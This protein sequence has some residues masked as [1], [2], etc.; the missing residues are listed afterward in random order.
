MSTPLTDEQRKLVEDNRWF[1]ISIAEKMTECKLDLDDRRQAGIIGLI[2]AVKKH[3]PSAGAL[4]TY[5]SR[6]IVNEIRRAEAKQKMIWIPEHM[7]MKFSDPKSKAAREKYSK[8]AEEAGEISSFSTR[9]F[10]MAWVNDDQSDKFIDNERTAEIKKAV[11]EA[12]KSLKAS[13]R[14]MIRLRVFKGM[15]YREIGDKHEIDRET[16]SRRVKLILKK[17]KRHPAINRVA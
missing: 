6:W 13:E 4:S 12:M 11:N 17:L 14:D 5:A 1:A 10:D 7:R 16:V 2:E 3:D 8:Q 15:T 9:K